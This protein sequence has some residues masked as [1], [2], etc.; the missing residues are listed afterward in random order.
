MKP[1]S[2][3]ELALRNFVALGHP[4][5]NQ[6]AVNSIAAEG[7]KFVNV[8]EVARCMITGRNALTLRVLLVQPCGDQVD[9]NIPFHISLPY[10]C[11]RADLAHAIRWLEHLV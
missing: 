8:W 2:T 6:R 7:A 10:A 3:A 4:G 9:V 11:S 1:L 5:A